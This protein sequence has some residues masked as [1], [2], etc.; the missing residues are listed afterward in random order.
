[1][2]GCGARWLRGQLYACKLQASR[3]PCRVGLEHSAG[4]ASRNATVFGLP[5]ERGLQLR[6]AWGPA[7]AAARPC[8]WPD[9]RTPGGDSKVGGGRGHMER[10][11]CRSARGHGQA[12][13]A[14]TGSSVGLSAH[15]GSLRSCSRCEAPPGRAPGQGGRGLCARTKPGTPQHTGT[16]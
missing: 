10:W 2:R 9:G 7:G 11:G 13:A 1:M 12:A 15:V 4:V 8:M 16:Y 14:G 5:L 3:A 6:V